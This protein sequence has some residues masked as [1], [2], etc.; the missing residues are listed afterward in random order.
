VDD[1]APYVRKII[2]F[3][4]T[5]KYDTRE[6]SKLF[7]TVVCLPLEV[8]TKRGDIGDP[9]GNGLAL[10]PA[11]YPVPTYR[12]IGVSHY[13]SVPTYKRIGVFH[14]TSRDAFDNVEPVDFRI[15]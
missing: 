8:V 5:V 2:H 12:K 15:I 3:N 4:G 7:S 1:G 13:P 10:V 6:D 14:Y 9:T 11:E